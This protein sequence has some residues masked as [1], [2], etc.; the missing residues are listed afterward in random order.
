MCK[1][2]LS[3]SVGEF[4]SFKLVGRLDLSFFGHSVDL[5]I[6]FLIQSLLFST[7]SCNVTPAHATQR[8]R[9]YH[10]LLQG[11]GYANESLAHS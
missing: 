5:S 3:P 1:C 2:Q 9:A 7:V 4:S 8:S 11:Q 10:E 6:L